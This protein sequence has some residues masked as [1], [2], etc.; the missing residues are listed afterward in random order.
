[1]PSPALQTSTPEQTPLHRLSASSLEE[2]EEDLIVAS[3]PDISV[4]SRAAL[5]D[6]TARPSLVNPTPRT[7]NRV[8]FALDEDSAEDAMELADQADDGGDDDDGDGVIDEDGY[9]AASSEDDAGRAPLLTRL[10]APSVV[11]ANNLDA[12]E[13]LGTDRPKSGGL[14]AF[15]NMANSIIGAGIIGVHFSWLPDRSSTR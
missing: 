4:S 7:P 1:M 5:P 9:A 13:L 8:R 3:N 11:V 2:E 14:H 10:A 15:M 12:S 6:I